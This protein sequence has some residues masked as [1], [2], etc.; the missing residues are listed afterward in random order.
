MKTYEDT[1]ANEILKMHPNLSVY[2]PRVLTSKFRRR[3]NIPKH[4]KFLGNRLESLS[5]S[6][7]RETSLTLTKQNT[8]LQESNLDRAKMPK[9]PED[10]QLTDHQILMSQQLEIAQQ[11]MDKIKKNKGE[12][13]TSSKE[14]FNE[15]LDI[16][17][18]Y[19][20]YVKIWTK[21][22]HLR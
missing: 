4:L 9:M 5:E 12:Y 2:I 13:I 11:I 18:A 15:N 22:F 6:L 7:S 21:Y 19:A 20:A 3:A 17:R 1:I 10:S 14:D 16:L 8:F